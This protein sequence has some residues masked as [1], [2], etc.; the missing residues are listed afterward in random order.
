M[1]KA[2]SQSINN[3]HERKEALGVSSA[4]EYQIIKV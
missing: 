4:W 1:L 3:N 2:E